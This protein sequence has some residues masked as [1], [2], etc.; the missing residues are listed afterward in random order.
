MDSSSLQSLAFL[1]GKTK[2]QRTRDI[3][4]QVQKKDLMIVSTIRVDGH[5]TDIHRGIAEVNNHTLIGFA[6]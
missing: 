3:N 5:D 1:S 4:Q 6:G 2:I